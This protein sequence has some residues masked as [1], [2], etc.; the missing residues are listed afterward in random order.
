MQRRQIRLQAHS[1]RAATGWGLG[2]ILCDWGKHRVI[3]HDG[4]TIGQFSFLRISPSKRI[5]VALL[6]NGGDAGGLCQDVFGPIFAELGDMHEPSA[7]TPDPRVRVEEARYLGNYENITTR[8]RISARR[9][10]LQLAAIP[11]SDMGA[12]YERAPIAF[13]DPQTAVLR[14]GSTILDRTSLLFSELVDD[15]YRYVQIGGRQFVRTP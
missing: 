12:G 13:V 2:W 5:A 7:G 3:G 4:G 6:T 9:G 14:T 15:A 10:Q 11:K 1:P 8:Y